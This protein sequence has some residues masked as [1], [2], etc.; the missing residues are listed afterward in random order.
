[1]RRWTIVGVLA[2]LALGT[3]AARAAAPG[4]PEARRHLQS[5]ALAPAEMAARACLAGAPAEVANWTVL[6]QVLAARGRHDEALTWYDRVLVRFP[7]E[8]DVAAARARTLAWTG[9]LDEAWRAVQALPDRDAD[10][11]MAVFTAN[12]ALWRSDFAEAGRRYDQVLARWPGERDALRG[13]AI[14]RKTTG[15]L[16]AA[17]ADWSALC[18]I[19]PGGESCAEADELAERR[20]WLRLRL[21]YGR[22]M[23]RSTSPTTRG[24]GWTLPVAADVRLTDHLRALAGVEHRV[25]DFG[26][27]PVGDTFIETSLSARLSPRWS[28]LAGAGATAARQ[29]SPRFVGHVEPSAGVGGGAELFLRYSRFDFPSGGAHVVSPAV[30]WEPTSWV[31]QGRYFWSLPDGDG[32]G[33]RH[34]GLARLSRAFG[35]NWNAS[36]GG[37]GGVGLDYLEIREGSTGAFWNVLASASRRLTRRHQLTFEYVHRREHG[38]GGRHQQHQASI[39]GET[40][41]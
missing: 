24:P 23:N 15:D 34:A 35:R 26:T 25:R 11:D 5:R 33:A 6:A 22:T 39:A 12:L 32:D 4:C 13:R 30:R 21:G 14:T 28:L 16:D 2:G 31:L 3:C 29:F 18:A 27:G 20:S 38:G 9:R 17:H 19:D 8:A 37:G 40:R 7:T 41:F 1:M 36:I 10:V